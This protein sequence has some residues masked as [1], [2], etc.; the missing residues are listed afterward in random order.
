M[1]DYYG[2]DHPNPRVPQYNVHRR[3]PNGAVSGTI[4]I[5]TAENSADTTLPDG[6][7]E[8]VARYI[9]SR[10]SYG[11]YHTLVDADSILRYVP[12]SYEAFHETRTNHWAIGISMAVIAADWS[13]YPASYVE[14]V[15][16]N[17]ARAAADT[18]REVKDS[19]GIVVP[20]A[21]IS[22]ADAL[23]RR[24]GF[25][26]HGEIDTARR[27]DPGRD[28]D[29]NRFLSYV[30]QALGEAPGPS[31]SPA[32]APS[33][34]L[35]VDGWWGGNTT[36][37]MQE[38]L[39]TPTDGKVSTQS[40]HWKASNPGLTTGWQWV[41]PSAAAGSQL[42]ARHQ[43]ILRDRGRYSGA[44]DGLVGPMYFSGLQA[45]LGTPVDGK[46]STQSRAVMALQ[47]RLNE[48]RV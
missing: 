4:V 46:I 23:N 36:W 18:V 35:T 30:S 32:P 28:F 39:G 15:Y 38:V 3:N 41:A 17:A 33:G 48:G 31:P 7:A 5:H 22:R 19:F 11:S 44:I 12:L 40:E 42:I 34:G 27:S 1:S 16:R 8:A 25:I 43:T 21:H 20:V 10:D 29:W 13:K 24:P 37:R 45:D 2:L 26:G 47:E 9:S 14:A 6:G